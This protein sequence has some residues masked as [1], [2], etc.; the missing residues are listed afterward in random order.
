MGYVRC[1]QNSAG[2]RRT[3]VDQQDDR[4][5]SGVGLP[6][7]EK[8]KTVL[9]SLFNMAVNNRVVGHHPRKVVAIS[10]MVEAP[11]RILTAVEYACVLPRLVSGQG[12]AGAAR[13]VRE[14]VALIQ[15]GRL[16]RCP[17][18]GDEW[19][20]AVEYQASAVYC[21]ARCRT[22]AWRRRAQSPPGADGAIGGAD[23]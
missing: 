11:L 23:S 6:T 18:C 9:C 4:G 7:I 22:R 1:R 19:I 16:A 3:D 12:V 15:A 2:A 8:C 14:R 20:R 10:A 21:S 5:G 13:A 17:E